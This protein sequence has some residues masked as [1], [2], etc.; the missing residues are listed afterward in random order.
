M[1]ASQKPK[2]PSMTMN[3][4]KD[5]TRTQVDMFCKKASRLTLSQVVDH[6]TVTETMVLNGDAR[7]RRY[8][9]KIA[10]FPKAELESEYDVVPAEILAA[11]ATRFPLIL[12]KEIVLEIK[13]LDADLRSQIAELGKGKK[14]AKIG[15]DGGDGDGDEGDAPAKKGSDYDQKSEIG[16]GD[17]DDTKRA[18]QRKQISSYESDDEGGEENDAEETPDVPMDVDFAEAG[19]NLQAPR[20]G[21]NLEK[22]I[23]SVSNLFQKNLPQ[24]TAFTFDES[25]CSFQLEV[26]AIN[27]PYGG[28]K[29]TDV[30]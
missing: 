29:T 20:L 8:T 16:D 13:K 21:R 25:V 1:T 22:E 10:F 9:V 26:S 19:K 15:R 11:F 17:A 5:V 18:R 7:W 2:T 24:A 27:P 12:K 3:L 6:V 28:C 4:C 14:T 23:G 30:R